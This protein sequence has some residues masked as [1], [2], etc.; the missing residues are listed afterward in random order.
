MPI[1]HNL[2]TDSEYVKRFKIDK[3]DMQDGTVDV[4]VEFDD[5]VLLQNSK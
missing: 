2:R 1:P 3:V 5:D 4:N